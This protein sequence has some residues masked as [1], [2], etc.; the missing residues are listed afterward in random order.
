M[1]RRVLAAIAVLCIVFVVSACSLMPT[2]PKT[3]PSITGTITSI[4]IDANGLGSILVEAPSGQDVAY[5]KA[6][7]AITDDTEV[8]LK[9]TDGWGRFDAVDL[10]KGDSVQVWFTGAVAESYP[11]QA[12]AATLVV[13]Y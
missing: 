13:S 5:D 12:T 9:A 11:V 3:T 4:S 8:L 7:V 10:N 2:P 1:P 6:S